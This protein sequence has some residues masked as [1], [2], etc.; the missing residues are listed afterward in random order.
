MRKF[1]LVVALVSWASGASAANFENPH[2]QSQEQQRLL[3]EV[4]PAN[5]V[6]TDLARR[7]CCS[8]HGGVSGCS[9]GSVTCVDGSFSPT[10][11]CNHEEPPH[12]DS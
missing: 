9:G 12:I 7:G 1:L 3:R 5:P 4:V 10:C 8:H 11:T 2:S 6:F